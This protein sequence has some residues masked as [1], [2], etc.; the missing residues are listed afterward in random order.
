MPKTD[1]RGNKF[2]YVVKVHPKLKT[3][4]SKSVLLLSYFGEEYCCERLHR[5][6][7]VLFAVSEIEKSIM[8]LL[9]VLSLILFSLIM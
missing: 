3:G 8:P 4:S 6:L 9:M 7:S 5:D 1:E 2:V